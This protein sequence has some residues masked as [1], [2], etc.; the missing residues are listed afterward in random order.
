MSSSNI[1]NPKT[2][3]NEESPLQHP[4]IKNQQK[5]KKFPH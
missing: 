1:H 2:Y 3:E 5:L 4:E